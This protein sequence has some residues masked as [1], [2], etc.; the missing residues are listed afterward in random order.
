MATLV[1]APDAYEPLRRS[2]FL[3]GSIEMGAAPD[4]QSRI[5]VALDDL[6]DL[7]LLNP[8]R[9]SWDSSWEQSI[10][11]PQFREQVQW[12]LEGLERS[13]VIAMYLDPATRAPVSLLELGLHA[14]SGKV[15]VLCPPG[16]WRRGN[17]EVVA[18]RYGIERH[19]AWAPWVE[20]LRRRL[21]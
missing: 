2:V 7:L 18:D 13:D 4:W 10:E 12:E 20:A 11:N 19:E 21:E 15:V 5:A 6:E 1:H 16:Y 14:R 3:A 17:V 8:R 9:P